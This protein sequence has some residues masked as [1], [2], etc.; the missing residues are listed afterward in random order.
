MESSFLTGFEGMWRRSTEDYKKGVTEYLVT[1]DTNVLLNLYRFTPQARDELLQALTK[2]EDRL[3]VSHQVVK[4]Y[5]SRRVD[6]IKEHIALYTTV[7]KVLNESRNK[8][9][10]EI[11]TF[12]KRRSMSP[13]EKRALI[14]PLNKAFD[15]A[16]DE[17][18]RHG[19]AFDLDLVKVITDDPILQS[20]ADIFD[21]K[22][23]APFAD[24]EEKEFLENYSTRAGDRIPPG[25][26]DSG[27]ADNA[28]GDYFVWEQVLREA[29][30]REMPVILVTNDTKDDWVYSEAG[31]TIGPHP[32]LISE[33]KERCGQDFLLTDLG[34]FLKVAKS[35]LGAIVSESTVAQ[36]QEGSSNT[37]TLHLHPDEFNALMV[38]LLK[39]RDHFHEETISPGRNPSRV[40]AARTIANRA[41]QLLYLIERSIE[42][43]PDGSVAL[44][45]SRRDWE[46][47]ED[48][49][50]LLGDLNSST[51]RREKSTQVGTPRP[52]K[53]SQH[54]LAYTRGR[55]DAMNTHLAELDEKIREQGANAPISLL[56]RRQQLA[57]E[58]D[59][60]NEEIA[61]LEQ[62]M[63]SYHQPLIDGSNDG[64]H[65]SPI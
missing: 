52:S 27:K 35:E 56:G 26:R 64:D 59:V 48:L 24:E 14:D 3:W 62:R 58:R 33:F 15:M 16:I 2:L 32:K 36:A 13:E 43:L 1:L 20:L 49:R 42:E 23:G 57:M 34:T 54:K 39:I 29:K 41:D 65:N 21:Q 61:Q 51:D 28:H 53:E 40:R 12:T 5:Y 18:K 50:A 6:A 63:P 45:I 60:L 7:P 46:M 10:Q 4:E 9:I 47:T 8:A 44:N 19:D 38:D 11:N 37:K 31:L 30:L 17:I 22:V 25:Y 55:L